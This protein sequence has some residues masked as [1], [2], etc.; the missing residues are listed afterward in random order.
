MCITKNVNK[1][2]S[3]RL[4][5]IQHQSWANAQYSRKECLDIV[6]IPRK[7]K[8][9]K[10]EESVVGIF[11][12]LGCIIDTDWIEACHGVSKN[13]NTVIFKFI[14]RKDCKKA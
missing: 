13:N 7:V 8:D 3:S 6:G 1:L 12:K 11:D 5:D 14:E 4:V 2:L 10:L 9:K